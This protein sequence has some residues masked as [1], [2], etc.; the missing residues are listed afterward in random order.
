MDEVQMLDANSSS[1]A[2]RMV[3]T[4]RRVN[5]LVLSGTPAKQDVHDLRSS[6]TFVGIDISSTIWDKLLRPGYRTAFEALFGQVAIR[7]TKKMVKDETG[8][9]PQTRTLIPITMNIVELQYYRDTLYR[10][11]DALA[12]S[13]TGYR[14]TDVLRGLVQTL[15]SICTHIQA[16]DHL[17]LRND[18]NRVGRVRLNGD[19][20]GV[21]RDMDQAL[22]K[23]QTQA[24]RD[25]HHL[26]YV[27]QADRIK[28]ALALHSD[29]KGRF[30]RSID[31]LTR[32]EKECARN[33]TKLQDMISQLKE[34][35]DAGSE[36][37]TVTDDG[38][39]DDAGEMS[40]KASTVLKS[41]VSNLRHLQHE[42]FFRLGDLYHQH[43]EE[44]G[45]AD[46]EE[47]SYNAA[48]AIR[49]QLLARP[50]EHSNSSVIKVQ[51]LMNRTR[52][53]VFEDLEVEDCPP[54]G[55]V[56]A[57]YVTMINDFLDAAMNAN[58]EHLWNLRGQV[59]KGL[60]DPIDEPDDD[61][62]A[63]GEEYEATLLAQAMLEAN[64]SAYVDALADRRE[65]LTSIG[66]HIEQIKRKKGGKRTT[67]TSKETA[68]AIPENADDTDHI[69][70]LKTTRQ[71]YR[72]AFAGGKS[73]QGL[74]LLLD[75]F[76]SQYTGRAE[77]AQMARMEQKRLRDIKETQL[78]LLKHLED[79]AKG[80]NQCFN[81]RLTYFRILQQISDTLV[82]K[83]SN[84]GGS[85]P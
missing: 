60:R 68:L 34:N 6:L 82:G 12:A 66:A 35:V 2:A 57:K 58:A 55:I 80:L 4:L 61:A 28:Y 79:E 20:G 31:M 37:D 39:S 84:R 22:G 38:D 76:A 40:N 9:P 51:S 75:D 18:D 52:V 69:R 64:M 15:R 1:K 17:R 14:D 11:I 65:I 48:T 27:L 7:H 46:M 78:T 21:L 33:V 41:R 42:A 30:R 10:N 70:D 53:R 77:E 36:E 3:T 23:M 44:E 16:N 13:S 67:Q 83:C 5:S 72:E 63:T 19:D 32:V 59:M 43:L 56:T 47:Q 54:L 25:Y 50:L 81:V 74:I 85:V 8:I 45:Y 73:L 71:A 62:H 29:D 26:I 49:Q 24:W